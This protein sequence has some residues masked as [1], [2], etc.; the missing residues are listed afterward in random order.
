MNGKIGL[1]VAA[2]TV[3]IIVSYGFVFPDLQ[4]QWHLTYEDGI[5]EN[6]GALAFL[7]VS[8]F[9]FVF[10]FRSQDVIQKK[11]GLFGGRNFIFMALALLFFVAF[12]EEISWGQRVFGWNTPDTWAMKNVQGETNIHNLDFFQRRKNSAEIEST[13]LREVLTFSPGRLFLYFWILFLV[14]IPTLA[15]F[16][17]KWH[18]FFRALR[19]P[20]APLWAGALMIL[21][22]VIAHL[23][24]ILVRSQYENNYKTV[25][26]FM[27]MNYAVIL[28]ALAVYWYGEKVYL[29]GDHSPRSKLNKVTSP[30]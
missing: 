29:P 28:L 30:P 26:E 6:L 21:N 14:A 16:S 23:I 9:F 27:E 13:F 5:V 20:I 10:F 17:N 1:L 25:D 8:L 4:Y 3:F 15:R 12:G 22:L 18:N 24:G 7:A 11:P 19:I 2:V